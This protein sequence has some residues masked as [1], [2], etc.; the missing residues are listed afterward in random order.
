MKV[1][2]WAYRY[3]ALTSETFNSLDDAVS[4][5]SWASDAGEEALH[6]F[7]VIDGEASRVIDKAEA[8]DLVHAYSDAEYAKWCERT[9][10]EP[11]ITHVIDVKGPDGVWAFWDNAH[12]LTE[13]HGKAL[14]FSGLVGP[15]RVKIRPVNSPR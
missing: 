6:S 3:G 11:K 2:K 4:A 1:I 7:E 9:K 14:E 10:D 5:A 15:D 12:S 8:F 13:A